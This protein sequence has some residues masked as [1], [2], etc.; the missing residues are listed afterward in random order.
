[1]GRIMNDIGAIG[2]EK[3]NVSQN[4]KFRGIDDMM[5]AFHS[6]FAKHGVVIIPNEL[7]HIQEI[8]E[9]EKTYQGKVEKSI[10]RWSRVHMQFTFTSTEDGSTIVADGWGEA[11]DSGD[12]GYNKCKSIALK[13]ILMDTFLVPTEDIA[14]PDADND[15]DDSKKPSKPAAQPKQTTKS[16][17]KSEP[18]SKSAPEADPQDEE[19]VK[20]IADCANMQSLSELTAHQRNHPRIAQNQAFRNALTKRYNEIN[21][22]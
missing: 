4:F 10:T 12:K 22:K 2:K 1:M 17:P 3:V 14:D 18:E 8:F 16:E 6:I 19:L 21:K 5:N 11:M 13:Y 9:K 7:E 20:A 15:V